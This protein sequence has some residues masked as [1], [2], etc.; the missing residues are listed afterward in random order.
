ME[1]IAN[2]SFGYD[3]LYRLINADS[4]A[5]DNLAR[6]GLFSTYLTHA[7][8]Y[9]SSITYEAHIRQNDPVTIGHAGP[10]GN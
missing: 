6:T 9:L 2:L 4:A 8:R 10:A 3:D 7:R 5:A 1:S